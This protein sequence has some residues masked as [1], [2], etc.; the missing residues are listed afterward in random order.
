MV[1]PLQRI[2]IE[3]EPVGRRAEFDSGVTLL[4][5]A[6]CS[7]VE[8]AS[9]CGGDGTCGCCRVRV[10]RGEVSPSGVT[11]R[12]EFTPEE[13]ADGMRLACQTHA[14]GDVLIDIPAESLTAAQRLQLEG[15]EGALEL[16]PPVVTRDLELA[17]PTLDDLRSDASRLRDGLMPL[18]ATVP[19]DVARQLP[20]TLRRSDWRTRA[21]V[22][23]LA[24]EV[25][26]L[27]EGDRA[28]LGLAVDLGTTKLAAYLVDLGTGATVARAGAMNPQIAYGEDVLSRIAYAGRETGGGRT[29][30]TVV[31]EQI[32]LLARDL[33]AET[34]C[35][36]DAIVDCVVVGN[37]AMHHLFAG[38]PVR[39]LGAAPYVAAESD[40]F[41]VRAADV[42]L[43]LS[44]GARL[45]SP[46]VIAG[47][48]GG[49]HVAMLLA[50]EIT[51]GTRRALALDI[52]TNTEISV[53][54]DGA[55]WSCST[56]SGP[57]FEGAHISA[58]MR[59]APGAIERVRYHEGA[60]T[61]Q[62]VDDRP[63]VGLCGSGMLDAI[64]AALDAG[65]IDRRGAL[66][67]SHHL[68]HA[69]NGSS[70]C[71]LVP[72]AHS[73][74]GQDIR[75]TRADVG[76][77]QLARGA[78][79]AGTALLLET[80]EIAPADLDVVIVAG[81]FGTYL[82]L[83][84]AVRVGLLPEIPLTRYRQV[85]NAAGAGARRLLLSRAAR[86][87]AAA[88]ASH[89]NYLELTTHPAFADRFAD[90]MRF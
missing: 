8:L 14:T 61:V 3:F 63:P 88:I 55:L 82:D 64:A 40:A 79:R 62:T 23:R 18:E 16:D 65:I 37:T 20:E 58:G 39:Q 1:E 68:V 72:A 30:Q 83:R 47:Y 81:A 45:Y 80:A 33:C 7:G 71:L 57:A 90:A 84:S 73:G 54:R 42:G 22:N 46:P 87:E 32:E 56:A 4:E 2:R 50:S 48:V 26:G 24:G 67:R 52:G 43:P 29:L 36:T 60:F 41:D 12:A 49:D 44:A 25:V 51:R 6:R 15:E 19:L 17:P 69:D 75:F 77:I 21:A 5:A 10:V 76:E 38:L 13:L 28:A 53:A 66:V 78:I 9:T 74:S 70:N 31:V 89:A 27:L 85:G 11:E 86:A 59:A 35:A 34:G